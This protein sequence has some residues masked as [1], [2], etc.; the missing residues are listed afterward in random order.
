MLA[1]TNTEMMSL[2]PRERIGVSDCFPSLAKKASP[3]IIA[4]GI[5]QEDKSKRQFV[6][7]P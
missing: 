2:E 5:L 7:A 6:A 4:P 3:W 1:D